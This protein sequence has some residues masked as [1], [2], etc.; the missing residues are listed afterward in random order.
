[1]SR[2]RRFLSVLFLV[3]IAIV[4]LYNSYQAVG[5]F[6]RLFVPHA[7]Y[8]LNQDQA[9]ARF[10]VQ[11][12]QPK[13]VPRLIHQVLHNWRPVGNDSALLPEWETQ[14]QSCRDQNPDW[15]YKGC[16]NS[17][18]S[19]RPYS[20]FIADHRRG[21]LSDKVLGGAPQHPFWV[22]VTETIPRHSHWYVF[23]SLAV[24]Y[25]T[26]R[27]FLTAAWDRWHWDNCQQS[28]FRTGPRAADWLTRL[29]MPRWRGAPEWSIF[30]SHR[31]G[32]A[33]DWPVDIFVLG[34]KH[35]VVSIVSG[36]VGVVVGVYLGVKLFRRRCAARRRRGYRPVVA[37]SRV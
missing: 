22:S 6:L 18:E 16:V 12:N 27:W 4:V 32:R 28:L 7:G 24:L 11:K 31:G 19:L 26:G 13:N 14:R 35:W 2:R 15:E 3:T 33:A 37:E 34:R 8:P 21:T 25:G 17:F 29:S 10:R 36:V 23:P 20:A 30:S 1:M 9:L 5:S